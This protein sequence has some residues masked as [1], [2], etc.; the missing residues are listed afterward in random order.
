[1][2]HCWFNKDVAMRLSILKGVWSRPRL[3]AACAVG[4]AVFFF[5]PGALQIRNTARLIVAWDA[6]MLVYLCACVPIIFS[7]N[8]RSIS[9]RAHQQEEG[10][11]FVLLSV[12]VSS[13]LLLLGIATELAVVKTLTGTL[14]AVHIG[15]NILTLVLSWVFTQTIFALH[16][17]H[18]YYVAKAQGLSGGLDFPGEDSPDYG[19]F[20]YFAFVI[21]TSGQTA[22][23]AYS[24]KAMRRVGLLHCVLAY[25]FNAT[26][27]ALTINIAAGLIST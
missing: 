7:S 25:F 16:Y 22:D 6:M 21:G 20:M 9:E 15:V 12:I 13:V 23:V 10:K 17:A 2:V 27:L 26:V 3:L 1:M 14:K 5:M 4:V 24:S 19:D 18:D 8:H 11:W